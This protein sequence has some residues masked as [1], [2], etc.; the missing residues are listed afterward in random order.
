MKSKAPRV[1]RRRPATRWSRGSPEL[2]GALGVAAV[3]RGIARGSCRRVPVAA[4][5]CR[6][7]RGCWPVGFGAGAEGGQ[8]GVPGGGADLGGARPRR[9]G[10]P[11]RSRWG[12][13][14]AGAA[15]GRRP[16][17]ARPATRRA[18]A[19]RASYQAARTSGAAVAGSGPIASVGS[20]VAGQ[21]PLGADRRGPLLPVE[22]VHRMLGDRS[23]AVT[24]RGADARRR[25]RRS[26]PG[27]P[28]ARRSR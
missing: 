5:R 12:R 23:R 9:T 4:R 10:V 7:R 18:R 2:L 6:V 8:V 14:H 28:S 3:M 20:S 13:C 1:G 21:F 24:A 15:A 11:R 17:R 22:P 16:C 25:A 26:G 27:R 19:A